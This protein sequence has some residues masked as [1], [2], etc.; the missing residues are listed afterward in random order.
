MK[1]TGVAMLK[2]RLSAYLRLV[3]RGEEVLVLERGRPVARIVPV[4]GGDEGRDE[5]IRLGLLRPGRGPVPARFYEREPRA[6]DPEGR[7]LAALL[8][9]REAGR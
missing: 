5:L 8:A 1:T 6:K 4:E 9:E 3:K 2:A 7:V